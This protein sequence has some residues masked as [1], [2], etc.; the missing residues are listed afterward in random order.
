LVVELEKFKEAGKDLRC[1][2][3][4]IGT[5]SRELVESMVGRVGKG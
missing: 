3:T 4:E 1:S 2:K 5:L